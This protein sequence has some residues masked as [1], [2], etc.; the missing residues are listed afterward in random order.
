MT[1]TVGMLLDDV[2]TRAWDL[3]AELEDRRAE[4]RYGERGLE[5]LAV[6]PRLATAA[7]R[8]LDAVPLEPAWLDDMGSVRLVLGQVGRGVL[9]ATADNGSAAASL[10]PDPA[11]GE[12]A[13]RLG[14][15]ADLLVGEKPA[16]TDVD[17]AALEGLQANVVSIVHAVATVSLPLLQDRDHLQAPRSVLAAVKA[18]TE[19][20]AMIP[21]ERR[22][23]RYED[24]GAVTSKSLDAA[25]STWVH[26]T[27]DIL[28]SR[29]G[30]SQA[31]LQVAAGDALIFTATAGTVCAA[32]RR[33]GL[34]D[35]DRAAVATSALGA[36]HAAWR[37]PAA[38]P[39]TVRLEGVRDPEHVHASRRLRKLVTDNLRQGRDWLPPERM[40][41]RFDMGL[42]LGT[43]RRGVHGVGNVALA[44]FQAL[45]TLVRGRGR[46]W[47][48]ASAVT[49]AAYRGPTTIE[50]A[51]RHGWVQM[52]LG[53][54]AGRA[55]HAD[56]KHAL[57]MT[58]MA[59]A[60]LD[61]TAASVTTRQ[62][63][64]GLRWDRARIVAVETTDQPVLFETV[65]SSP[66]AGFRAEQRNPIQLGGRPAP[67]PRR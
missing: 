34:V 28:S 31:A 46:L 26:A 62:S 53:E 50:A 45:D 61:R 63:D 64:G 36:A 67:G 12:L 51:R 59:L 18:R 47:I 8:V 32:A 37:R 2:H 9:E 6:W 58:T 1:T 21:A 4:N 44:H 7:L 39:E 16:R 20:F 54:P 5:V 33:L 17:R 25:I 38:W 41:D 57:D 29:R 15:I 49:Q 65:R 42:L 43:M 14:L 13:L 24:V 40:A 56:A 52:P 55:L 3:C 22:S 30:V 48:A 27:V 35:A 19:R 60:A 23:G 66:L 11:V 10:K